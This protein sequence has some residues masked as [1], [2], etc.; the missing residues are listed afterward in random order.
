MEIQNPLNSTEILSPY[1]K[2]ARYRIKKYHINGS[3]Y[4]NKTKTFS[5]FEEDYWLYSV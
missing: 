2:V 4:F 3:W 1:K 5:S